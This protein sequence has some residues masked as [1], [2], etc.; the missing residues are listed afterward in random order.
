[1]A[2]QSSPDGRGI[3]TIARCESWLALVLYG[4]HWCYNS[5][6]QVL[7]KVEVCYRLLHNKVTIYGAWLVQHTLL[8]TDS[9]HVFW[10]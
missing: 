10:L 9:Q 4:L 2:V 6:T 7:Q 8:H 5:V 1:M 3:I